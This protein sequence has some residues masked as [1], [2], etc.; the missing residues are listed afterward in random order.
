[1]RSRKVFGENFGFWVRESRADILI[2]SM[3]NAHKQSDHSSPPSSN[4]HDGF[5]FETRMCYKYNRWK[6][7]ADSQEKYQVNSVDELRNFINGG[8]FHPDVST[9]FLVVGPD[10]NPG[11]AELGNTLL[12]FCGVIRP[13][14]RTVHTM[15]GSDSYEL[16]VAGTVEPRL[17]FYLAEVQDG[18]IDLRVS[19]IGSGEPGRRQENIASAIGLV[20]DTAV[21]M[22]G[23]PGEVSEVTLFKFAPSGQSDSGL[24]IIN[25]GPG[26]V[27]GS[28]G[29]S[30]MD[31]AWAFGAP[32]PGPL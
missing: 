5:A 1:M 4:Y 22:L 9:P 13:F 23:S 26:Q 25:W 16:V 12:D 3:A 8:E 28:G 21:V 14:G 2:S 18:Q 31:V 29:H 10:I 27:I 11:F 6:I 19:R 17:P 15:A 30:A 20:A 32:A 24:K 7:M